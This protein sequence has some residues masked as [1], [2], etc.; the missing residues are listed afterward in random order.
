MVIGG[1]AKVADGTVTYIPS[2][3]AE[4][5]AA[6]QNISTIL[7]S[8][9]EFKSGEVTYEAFLN[10]PA[11]KCQVGVHSEMGGKVYAGLNV[12]DFAYGLAL[13]RNNTWEIV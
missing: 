3:I 12:G 7:R 11:S 8:N 6:G 9:M 10:E 5:P 4:G 13:F 1:K 2:P